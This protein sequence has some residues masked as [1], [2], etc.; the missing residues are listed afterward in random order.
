MELSLSTNMSK[1]MSDRLRL[2]ESR[3]GGIAE[4]VLAVADLPDPVGQVIRG[5]NLKNGL[6]VIQ[7]REP[8]GVIAMI[9][10]ARPNVIVDAASL[11]IKSG[12]TCILRGGKE[13]FNSNQAL[14]AIIREAISGLLPED[15]VLLVEKP[16]HSHVDDILTARGY[17][18]LV[19]PRGSKRLIDSVVSRAKVPVI[20]TGAGLCHI[21]VSASADFEMAKNIIINA[22]AQRPSVCNSV[23]NV[24]IDKAVVK[25]FA[26][27]LKEA[28][29]DVHVE[30]R[31]DSVITE[32]TGTIPATPEDFHTEYLDYILSAAT[33]DGLDEAI[34]FINS[35][36]SHH[37]EA[38][39]TK[40]INEADQFTRK[41]DSACVFVNTSTRF[42]DGGEFGY[43]AEIGISTQKTHAR[44]P[45][46]LTELT[47]T[48][49]L[50]TGNGQVRS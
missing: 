32:L 35:H 28:M 7:V 29:D 26:P 8:I 9:F 23:E 27:I 10:E 17:I 37:S 38:I 49:Y 30:L 50:I 12:N 31:G 34:E 33:V 46:G 36:S 3:I 6:K 39:I 44:G 15:S 4:G 45:V 47:T 18:D 2:T 13:A 48:K 19:I 16:E 42:A 25:E 21:Y 14:A 11:A 43:G 5:N 41:I 1:A 40:D 22:K 20:E 24:L